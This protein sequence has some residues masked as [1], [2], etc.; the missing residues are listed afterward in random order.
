MPLS[1][2]FGQAAGSIPTGPIVVVE[3]YLCLWQ[4]SFF[5]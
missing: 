1:A 2:T 3:G 5:V 4:V